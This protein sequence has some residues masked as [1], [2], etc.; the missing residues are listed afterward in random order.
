VDGHDGFAQ[1]W[2]D[3]QRARSAVLGSRSHQISKALE[4]SKMRRSYQDLVTDEDRLTYRK[5]LRPIAAAYGSIA[6]LMVGVAIMRLNH[7]SSHE[8]A[9]RDSGAVISIADHSKFGR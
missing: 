5:W 6:L 8:T 3:A 7:P 9:K 2:R 1:L 4:A